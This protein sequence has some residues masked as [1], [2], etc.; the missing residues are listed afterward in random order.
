MG[1]LTSVRIPGRAGRRGRC[2]V[3]RRRA[4]R[5]ARLVRERRV[6]ASRRR[7]HCLLLRRARALRRDERRVV[8][9]ELGGPYVDA[10]R[11][12]IPSGGSSADGRKSGTVLGKVAGKRTCVAQFR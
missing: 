10:N 7:A 8:V 9:G 2:D 6:L 5:Y 4:L 12:S 11:A 3:E 1:V